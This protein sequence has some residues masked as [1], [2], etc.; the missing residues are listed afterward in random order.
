MGAGLEDLRVALG[1]RAGRAD[2][3]ALGG[4]VHQEL[5]L[6]DLFLKA[7]VDAVQ[8]RLLG[9]DLTVANGIRSVIRCVRGVV[10]G[11]P[12]PLLLCVGQ[13]STVREPGTA[14]TW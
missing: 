13:P 14:R 7:P 6:V 5:C 9:F 4:V 8:M 10:R 12:G 2:L 11:H 3:A 1:E